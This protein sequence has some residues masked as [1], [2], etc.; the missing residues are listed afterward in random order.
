[1]TA[2]LTNRLGS[3]LPLGSEYVHWRRGTTGRNVF[4]H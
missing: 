2:V 4:S 1:V 3:S